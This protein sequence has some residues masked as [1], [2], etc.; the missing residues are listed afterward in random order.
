MDNAR[1]DF[2]FK[3]YVNGSCSP[4][5]ELELMQFI[6]ENDSQQIRALLDALWNDTPEKLPADKA[7]N[8]LHAILTFS[9]VVPIQRNK[10]N[11]TWLKAA[12]AISFIVISGAVAYQFMDTEDAA[13]PVERMAEIS[14]H[15]YIKLPDG[16]TV[17]LNTGS[18]ISYPNSFENKNTREVHL[19]GEGFFDIKHDA[20]KPFVVHTGKLSTTVLGTAFNIRAYPEQNDITVTVARGKVKVS[21]ELTV[22]G[23]ISPDQ[24]ITFSKW[25]SETQQQEIKSKDV[26]A[27]TERDIF[28]DDIS[29]EDAAQ[30]LEDRFKI[31]VD[32]ANEK[33]KNCRFTATF[34]MGE[35]LHQILDVI[36]EFNKATY[37]IKT[38]GDIEISGNGCSL[39][40]TDIN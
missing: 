31:Q 18:K 16:S 12:A 27:W 15:Q 7:E 14:H 40:D 33:I 32:F 17:I 34:T 1:L 29:M 26:I 9:D 13:R 28:F 37:V 21:N 3:R 25:N 2:L 23:I 35:D 22:L 36:C 5:E 6:A 8:I 30:Q 11:F 20:S 4:Q 38:S 24:Q 39:N 19:S 10:R